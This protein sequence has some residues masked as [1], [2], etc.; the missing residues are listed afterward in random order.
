[1]IADYD[2]KPLPIPDFA[3]VKQYANAQQAGGPY[4][5][6]SV[7]DYWPGVDDPSL[8]PSARSKRLRSRLY[9]GGGSVIQ[10]LETPGG[11]ADIFVVGSDKQLWWHSGQGAPAAMASPGIACGGDVRAISCSYWSD[12]SN[13]DILAVDA[14]GTLRLG[15]ASISDSTF[16]WRDPVG[17][18]ALTP[19]AHVPPDMTPV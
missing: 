9:S 15:V 17:G 16:R 6:S 7:L 19:L 14:D 10:G 11:R 4:D 3:V 1:M 2:N 12:Y 8:D 13:I 18:P 5:L